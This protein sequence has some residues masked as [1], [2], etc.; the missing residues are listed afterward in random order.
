VDFL[1]LHRD[2]DRHDYFRENLAG[3]IFFDRAVDC[4][5]V[6]NP[7][8]CEAL[9]QSPLLAMTPYED[10]Y[11]ALTHRAGRDFPNLALAFRHI[12]LCQNGETHRAA[13]RRLADIISK[14]QAILREAIPDLVSRYF[15]LLEPGR[16]VDLIAEIIDPLVTDLI[17]ELT[18]T[19]ITDTAAIVMASVVF[20]R[21]LGLK[22]RLRIEEDLGTIREMIRKSL[23]PDAS[24]E[25]EGDRL[26]LF[27][28]GHDT[29]I[30][31]LGE[32]LYQIFR[33]NRDRPLNEIFF[34]TMPIETGVPYVERVAEEAIEIG[35]AVIAAGDKVRLMLQSFAYS[36]EAAD[37]ARLFGI[38]M[39]TCLGRQMSLDIWAR[40]TAA[41]SVLPYSLEIMDYEMRASD[42][43]F[44]RPER[45]LLRVL[46]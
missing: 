9:L 24:E 21:M 7:R 11:E 17:G 6:A 34:P 42:Y 19:Q 12:P 46:P 38:G 37:R 4:W 13:R 39:H 22:K 41:L 33:A 16:E 14:R 31:T 30:G 15:G 45:L 1:T 20:D 40:T 44:T 5:I 35:G 28:L 27:V 43:T 26:A 29:L 23:G 8:H 3:P 36:G 2:V 18:Q 25:E 32:S 10:A